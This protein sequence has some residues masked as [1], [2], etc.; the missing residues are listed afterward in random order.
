MTCLERHQGSTY[1]KA[2]QKYIETAAFAS[3]RN[4][5]VRIEYWQAGSHGSLLYVR[6]ADGTWTA[7]PGLASAV[8]TARSIDVTIKQ[9]LNSPP[10]LFSTD[11]ATKVGRVLWDPN[12]QLKAVEFGEVSTWKWKD[13][14]G[15]VWQGGLYKPRGY[16]SG[17]RYPLVVQ[18]HGFQ[19]QEF[20]PSGNWPTGFAAQQLSAAGFLVLQVPDCP[21]FETPQEG[22]CNVAGYEAGAARLASEGLADPLRVGIIGF[23]RTCFSVM[24]ALTRGHLHFR[25]ASI[26]EGFTMGYMGY[27]RKWTMGMTSM[28]TPSKRR[29]VSPNPSARNSS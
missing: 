13:D 23:S 24:T 10:V 3:D 28:R 18:T 17:R 27:H 7:S 2:S 4:D 19:K 14:T 21:L 5:A 29:S 20:R 12:P 6:S 8:N 9:D 16:V 1:K 26:T 22:P 15:R 25:A 11:T